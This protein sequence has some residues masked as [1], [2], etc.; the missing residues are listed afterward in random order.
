MSG[1]GAVSGQGEV[2]AWSGDGTT[3]PPEQTDAC[4]NITFPA[5][6]RNAGR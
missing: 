3:I 2:G 5:L 4:E 1:L 6:L